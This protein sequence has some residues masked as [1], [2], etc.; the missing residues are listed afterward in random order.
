MAAGG[1]GGKIGRL[2]WT[3]CRGA[4]DSRSWEERINDAS[5]AGRDG[6]D[7]GVV[8]RAD[9]PGLG[10]LCAECGPLPEAKSGLRQLGICWLSGREACDA[11]L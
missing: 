8:P 5:A 10:R 6:V 1:N 4:L 7:L 3:P 9:L 2:V 11:G